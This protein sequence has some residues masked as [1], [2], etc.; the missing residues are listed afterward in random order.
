MNFGLNNLIKISTEKDAFERLFF[1]FTANG[2]R[3]KVC[4]DRARACL[5]TSAAATL[6]EA[7]DA[8]S[9]TRSLRSRA[10]KTSTRLFNLTDL[11]YPQKS[12]LAMLCFCG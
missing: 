2:N 9:V 10:P 6:T 12:S 5:D 8:A 3:G 11:I 4:D 7:A 1:M